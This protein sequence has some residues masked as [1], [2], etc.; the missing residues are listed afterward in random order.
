[1]LEQCPGVGDQARLIPSGRLAFNGGTERSSMA[2]GGG[3][4]WVQTWQVMDSRQGR[5][6]CSHVFMGRRK[7]RLWLRVRMGSR[8]GSPKR[9]AV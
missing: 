7:Q 9:G 4:M 5:S 1:M 8:G 6:L 3:S 2:R